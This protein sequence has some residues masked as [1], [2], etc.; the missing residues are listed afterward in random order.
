MFVEF[1]LEENTTDGFI[2]TKEV[3]K[4]FLKDYKK[5][6]YKGEKKEKEIILI[7]IS[8]FFEMIYLY[9]FPFI[10]NEKIFKEI[11]N[12]KSDLN[13]IF[14]PHTLFHE[15]YP[16]ETYVHSQNHSLVAFSKAYTMLKVLN[17]DKIK[18]SKYGTYNFENYDGPLAINPTIPFI[19]KRKIEISN[20]KNSNNDEKIN[21]LIKKIKYI[22]TEFINDKNKIGSL[23]KENI[24][25]SLTSLAK[26]IYYTFLKIGNFNF[27]SKDCSPTSEKFWKILKPWINKKYKFN[28]VSKIKIS[29]FNKI[30]QLW[31][32]ND[33]GQNYKSNVKS[34]R[35]IIVHRNP[36]FYEQYSNESL[37]EEINNIFPKVIDLLNLLI[38]FNNIYNIKDKS[39]YYEKYYYSSKKQKDKSFKDFKNEKLKNKEIMRANIKKIKH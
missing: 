31:S 36:M 14:D 21:Y 22:R 10:W 12:W 4:C 5:E 16:K 2:L 11:K 38:I 32:S 15:L 3:L 13:N 37:L 6:V 20:I 34:I 39:Q 26:Q 23:K 8:N 29:F 1:L 30:F 25:V 17:E 19:T 33:L 28:Y 24:L 18:I 35:N 27:E 7:I 9:H